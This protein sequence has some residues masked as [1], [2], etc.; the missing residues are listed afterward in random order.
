MR[1]LWRWFK[2]FTK[3]SF[4]VFLL[5]VLAFSC[6]LWY[7]TT[8]SFQQMARRRLIADVESATG[9]RAEV[10][11]FHVVPLHFQVEVRG[12]TIHGREAPD[13]VPYFHVESMVATVN[14][15]AALGAK[16]SF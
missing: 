4:V 3:Y 15:S 9:G 11:S 13:Q 16:I 12:L 10:G 7:T 5:L 1:V 14:L 6:F 8:D 2:K